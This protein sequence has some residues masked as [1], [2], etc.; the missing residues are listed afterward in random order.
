MNDPHNLDSPSRA[1]LLVLHNH[2]KAKRKVRAEPTMNAPAWNRV[3][4]LKR[5]GYITVEEGNPGEHWMSLTAVG[6]TVVESW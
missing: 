6:A 5:I 2:Y 1:F 4:T 3:N